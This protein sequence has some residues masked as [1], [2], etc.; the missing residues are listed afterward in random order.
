M[1][2]V[3]LRCET[4]RYLRSVAYRNQGCGEGTDDKGTLASIVS[5][6]VQKEGEM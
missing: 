5:D 1:E 3:H 6:K 4:G 2:K